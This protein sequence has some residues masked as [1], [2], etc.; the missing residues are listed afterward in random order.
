MSVPMP[1]K[2]PGV[3]FY[4]HYKHDP[5]GTI[6]NYVYEVMGIGFHT[7]DDVRPSEKHFVVYRP[8]YEAAVYQAERF[9]GMPCYDSRPLGM[10]MGDV[11]KEGKIMPRYVKITDPEVIEKLTK[12]Q[13]EM[14]PKGN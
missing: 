14:Y 5:E 9:L 13:G 7:E 1:E 2:V 10:W 12:I 11:E 4:N 8:L 6:N 3:G